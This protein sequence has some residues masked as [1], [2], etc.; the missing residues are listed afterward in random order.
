M[1]QFLAGNKVSIGREY[2]EQ[3]FTRLV[4]TVAWAEE[5]TFNSTGIPA[6]KGQLNR[7]LGAQHS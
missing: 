7:N 3:R 6:G 4:K 2:R 1:V 5:Y